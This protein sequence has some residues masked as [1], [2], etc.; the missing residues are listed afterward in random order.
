MGKISEVLRYHFVL[1]L[2]IRQSGKDAGVSKS[3]ASRYC[4]RF[5]ELNVSIDEFLALNELQQEK[6]F[7]PNQL[8]KPSSKKV[9]PDINYIHNELKRRK[10]T[11]ETTVQ[12]KRSLKS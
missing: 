1:K 6:L 8:Q 2:S 11:K 4:I 5:N 7:Y 10:Y 9:M 3:V 12:Q